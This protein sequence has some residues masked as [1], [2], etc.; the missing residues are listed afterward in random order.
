MERRKRTYTGV[1]TREI[2]ERELKNR[3]LARRAAAQGIVLLRNDDR[4]L[5]LQEG[6]EVALYGSGAVFTI[7]GGTGSGD[8]NERETVSIYEGM[9]AAGFIITN[10][11]W[12]ASYQ[13]YYK[14]AKQEWKEA[15]L[16]KTK[17]APGGF[18]QAYTET[19]FRPPSGKLI[20]SA[21]VKKT[22]TAFYVISRV[23]GEG[24][25]RFYA[26]GDYLLTSEEKDMIHAVDTLYHN[27]ILVLNT[28]G[29][30]DLSI[31]EETQNIK[32]LLVLSQPGM[33][34]GN[35]FAD[36]IS[37]KTAPSGKLTDTWA[38]HYED[39]PNSKTFSHNNK[40]TVTEKYEEGIFVG[41]RYFDSF[42]A[43]P[44]YPF[45]YGLSYTEFG[46]SAG[47]VSLT[48]KGTK[49]PKLSVEAAIRN[50]G[51]DCSG[52]EVVQV[53]ATC[54]RGKM[55][56]EYQRLCAFAK[57]KELKPG[58]TQ[59]LTITFP[60]G[61]LA[62]YVEEKAVWMLEKGY[63]GI[64]IGDSSRDTKLVAALFVQQDAITAELKNICVRRQELQEIRPD[65]KK[66]RDK[67]EYWMDKVEKKKV[68]VLEIKGSEILMETVEYSSPDAPYAGEWKELVDKLTI[69]QLISLVTGDPG[70]GQNSVIG[71]AGLTVPGAAGETSSAALDGSNV[72]SIVLADGPAGLRLSN[73]Y[74]VDTDGT[75]LTR[76]FL[77]SIEGGFFAEE[78]KH[79]EAE[80][81]YQYCT[82]IPVGTMLAQS[83]DL[84][85][86]EEVGKAIAREMEEFEVTLWLAP[87][88]NIHRNPLC[89]R[90]FEYYSEDPLVSGMMA[91]AMTKGVQALGG[92]GTTIKHF[93]CNNQEDNRK[94]SNSVISERALREIYLKG[95]EI[96]V[97][98]SQPM[99]IMTSYNSING[100]QTANSYDL[101]TAVARDEWGFAG[102]IMTD[103]GTTDDAD[104]KSSSKGCILAGNDLIMPGLPSNHEELR[105]A[106]D[107]GTL[108]AEDLKKCAARLISIVFQ[109]NQYQ[110]AKSYQ[111]QF[112]A[113][114]AYIETTV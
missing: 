30:M 90:N 59:K 46:I 104:G 109:S 64:W 39:Y 78:T 55:A 61:Q 95:F 96:A 11:D 52:R 72:A 86:V 60:L 82:A 85:L 101:C 8:V 47:A 19:A 70:K 110:D 105:A 48:G 2:S 98:S 38:I 20:G 114:E 43:E 73:H 75:I 99:S 88:M 6:S 92:T 35:A 94:G 71:A 57:T 14:T 74:E 9:K 56:K 23:A 7:K 83:F 58:E 45:G 113:L 53:Y 16:E 21:D 67:T 51:D 93:A 50:I 100:V 15:I 77:A 27:V 49:T 112:G 65:E 36:V 1:K 108:T 80:V 34:G 69:E 32:A 107:D 81:Y 12:I 28:G 87:G 25:D 18:F 63:Y 89:G 66:L 22:K 3:V 111:E 79:P 54:P 91:A 62:S 37:G 102:I 44:R 31:L 17:T 10:E 4:V 5:P 26:E 106:I 41:Y 76:D 29:V 42:L 13:E 24:A 84:E 97:K 33:E 68:P 103:W 40:D